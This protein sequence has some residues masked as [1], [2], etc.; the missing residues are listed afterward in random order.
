M[1]AIRS[2]ARATRAK[3]MDVLAGL[4]RTTPTR[5]MRA[6]GN[7][8]TV[9]DLV[10]IVNAFHT[11]LGTAE[12]VRQRHL[13]LMSSILRC[14]AGS[15]AAARALAKDVEKASG[16]GGEPGKQGAFVART[17]AAKEAG[18]ANPACG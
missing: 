18:L 16:L 11:G 13:D 6:A 5:A 12:A 2:Q 15:A 1:A 3:Q 4:R 14:D 17:L 9:A 7:A 10:S 8:L